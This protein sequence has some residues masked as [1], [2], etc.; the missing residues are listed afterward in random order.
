M[1]TTRKST[2]PPSASDEP[3]RN[4]EPWLNLLDASL[5]TVRTPE[6]ITTMSLPEVYSA[7]A[8]N[9]VDDFVHLRP[10]QRHP[11][12]SAICQIGAVAMVN[13]GLTVA[14]NDAQQWREMLS[15]LS[16]GEHPGHEP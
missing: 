13:A 7:L 2:N 14:P 15:A 6:G 1:P 16:A 4:E 5:I 3:A 10:H 12:H 11:L 9:A 8:R